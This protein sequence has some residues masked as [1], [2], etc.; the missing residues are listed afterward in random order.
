[1][2]S[3]VFAIIQYATQTCSESERFEFPGL[4]G[5]LSGLEKNIGIAIKAL[6]IINEMKIDELTGLCK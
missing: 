4:P 2:I 3:V 6:Q 5:L 1:M